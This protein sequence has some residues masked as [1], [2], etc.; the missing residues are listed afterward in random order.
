MDSEDFQKIITNAIDNEVESYTFYKSV[1]DRVKDANLKTI[2]LDLAEE[3]KGHREYLQGLLL[4]DA[5][6]MHFVAARDY[7]VTDS[8]DEP[9]L[10]VDMKPLDGLVLAIKKELQAAQMY[11]QLAAASADAEQKMVFVQLANM[12]KGHKARLEDIY[13]NMAYPEAW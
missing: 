8:I 10:S 5:K 4:R 11:T 9:V 7:K 2:F 3:E 1:A 13:T 12:E 6:Q